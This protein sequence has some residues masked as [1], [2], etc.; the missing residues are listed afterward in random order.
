MWHEQ[1]GGV[2]ELA[3]R[4]RRWPL[5]VDVARNWAVILRLGCR[6][7]DVLLAD[8]VQQQVE[9]PV[10]DLAYEYREG[11]V[12]RGFVPASSA[13]HELGRRPSRRDLVGARLAAGFRLSPSLAAAPGA[14][15]GTGAGTGSGPRPAVWF[16][17]WSGRRLWTWAMPRRFGDRRVDG[18][19]GS[20]ASEF[21]LW[22]GAGADSSESGLAAGIVETGQQGHGP[23]PL[24]SSSVTGRLVLGIEESCTMTRRQTGPWAQGPRRP[25]EWAQ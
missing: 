23:A 3:A 15:G 17:A 18:L 5:A 19:G 4:L 14:G 9:G 13:S 7:V 20:S 11:R 10:I 24:R 1:R 21:W 25:R 8:Q 16:N 12:F 22:C 2:D 6:R